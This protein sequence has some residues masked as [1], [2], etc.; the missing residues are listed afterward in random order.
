MSAAPQDSSKGLNESAIQIF[1]RLTKQYPD[2]AVLRYHLGVA[3]LQ[4]GKRE[5][6][7]AQFAIGLS[8]KPSKEMADKIKDIVA[9]IG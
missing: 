7:K 9:K 8:K 3:L 1:N 4:Q 2:E 6:A 5:E